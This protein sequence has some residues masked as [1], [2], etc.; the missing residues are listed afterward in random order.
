MQTDRSPKTLE[1]N[2]QVDVSL[3]YNK[4]NDSIP[5]IV[6]STKYILVTTLFALSSSLYIIRCFKLN[7]YVHNSDLKSRFR[8]DD[9][10]RFRN[11]DLESDPATTGTPVLNIGFVSH[12]KANILNIVIKWK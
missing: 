5:M 1:F 4:Y 11:D 8:N 6:Q 7:V 10:K 2:I 9:L 12:L 3:K